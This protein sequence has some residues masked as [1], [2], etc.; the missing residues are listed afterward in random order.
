MVV[1]AP[2]T[3]KQSDDTRVKDTIRIILANIH[4][5]LLATIA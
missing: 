5:E 2:M 4:S 1:V 3:T